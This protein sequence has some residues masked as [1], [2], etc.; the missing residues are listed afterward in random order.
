MKYILIIAAVAIAAAVWFF[1]TAP[2]G[3]PAGGASATAQ[4]A[5]LAPRDRMKALA[6][7]MGMKLSM[8]VDGGGGNVTFAVRVP[9]GNAKAAADFLAAAKAENILV[10]A[11][12]VA[13]SEL[14]DNFNGRMTETQYQG[15]LR[16]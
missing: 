2:S 12:Q 11:M 7:T 16:Q 15:S 8:F 5:S 3:P 9:A 4:A 10:D 6:E 13:S 14:N 1:V